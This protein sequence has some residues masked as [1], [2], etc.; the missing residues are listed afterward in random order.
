MTD[1]EEPEMKRLRMSE[2]LP[3]GAELHALNAESDRPA[4]AAYVAWALSKWDTAHRVM[5]LRHLR[6]LCVRYTTQPTPPPPNMT[7]DLPTEDG[8]AWAPAP[9]HWQDYRWDVV[10]TVAAPP[11]PPQAPAPPSPPQSFWDSIP[12]Q[13]LNGPPSSDDDD[14]AE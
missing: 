1:Q 11:S 3:N 14:T 4:T 8:P 12:E 7:W 13:L 10:A 2:F 6:A 5:C 9:D